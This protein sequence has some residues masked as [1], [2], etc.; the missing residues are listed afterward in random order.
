M[1]VL[2][3]K[4]IH[5]N[6]TLYLASLCVSAMRKKT[7]R[8]LTFSE[9]LALHEMVNSRIRMRFG[10]QVM[11]KELCNANLKRKGAM[12]MRDAIFR[13]SWITM[14]IDGLPVYGKLGFVGDEDSEGSHF[15]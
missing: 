12:R 7:H 5:R 11:S 2:I 14:Y 4:I 15:D 8:D 13:N 3:L 6:P 1:L 9:N 10:E